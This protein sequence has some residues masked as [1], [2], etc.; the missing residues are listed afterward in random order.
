MKTRSGKYSGSIEPHNPHKDCV[1]TLT[2]YILVS[3][4]A[5]AGFLNGLVTA[6]VLTTIEGERGPFYIGKINFI[7]AGGPKTEGHQHRP[8]GKMGNGLAGERGS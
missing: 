4:L 1:K 3:G 6:G 2:H 7:F 5:D 8:T